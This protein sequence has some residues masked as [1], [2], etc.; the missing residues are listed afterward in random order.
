MNPLR[1]IQDTLKIRTAKKEVF[2]LLKSQRPKGLELPYK[3]GDELTIVALSLL[4]EHPHLTVVKTDTTM[5]LYFREDLD[6]TVSPET[7]QQLS[8]AGMLLTKDKVTL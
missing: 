2:A 7:R 5:T 1:I 3:E 8:A 6:P 4:K